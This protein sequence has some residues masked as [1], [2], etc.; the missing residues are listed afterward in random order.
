MNPIHVVSS[1]FF[2]PHFNTNPSPKS[3]S[4]KLSRSCNFPLQNSICIP[5]LLHTCHMPHPSQALH[6]ITRVIYGDDTI[7]E[8]FIMPSPLCCHSL[9]HLHSAAT[10]YDI[11]STLL[12]LVMPSPLCCHSLCH[13]HSAA[14]HFA[15]STLLP[16]IMPLPLCCHSLCHIHPAAT[17]Y[18]ISTLLPLIMPS[19]PCCH[20][21]CHFLHPAITL[22]V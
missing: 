17:H 8:P 1:Y 4:S 6:L 19:P 13:L 5:P 9:C 21:L 22:F 12:P 7:M 14:T 11:S 3:G 2:N 15:I 10:H 16:L 20:S 18:A